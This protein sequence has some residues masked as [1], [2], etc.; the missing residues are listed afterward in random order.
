[1]ADDRDPSP[2]DDGGIPV[3]S[4]ECFRLHTDP[5]PLIAAR[6]PRRWM[7]ETTQRF[8]YRCT[9]MTMANAS[10]WELQLPFSFSAE[11]DG[12]DGV[13]AITVASAARGPAIEQLM[14]SHFGHGILTFHPGWLFRTSPGWAIW[15]R[16]APNFLKDGIM[17]LEGLV[18]TDWL[19]FGFTMNWRFTRPGLVR[20]EQ[21]DPFCFITLAPH[22]ALDLVT[23]HASN[24]TDHAAL[25]SEYTRWSESRTDFNSRL[26]QSEPSAIQERWQRGY[27]AGNGAPPGGHH[28]VKR[29]LKSPS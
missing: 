22:G 1:M 26:R 2:V 18:E 15:A 13:E 9:P 5:P 28:I 29:K 25:L 21:G 3:P 24:L 17:P 10:G 14:A 6:S 19:P 23:P 8:A 16:G 27:L 11:W 4:L 20:F 12:G 7:D